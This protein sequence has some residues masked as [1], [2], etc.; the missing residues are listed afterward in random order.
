MGQTRNVCYIV[1]Y[2][3]TKCWLVSYFLTVHVTVTYTL[4]R[5]EFSLL[6]LT[7]GSCVCIY[8]CVCFIFIPYM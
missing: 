6:V 5:T 4:S 7:P 8:I 3:V 1:H 2:I